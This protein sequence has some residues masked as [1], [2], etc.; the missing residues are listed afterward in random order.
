MTME[1]ES[2]SRL[3]IIYIFFEKFELVYIPKLYLPTQ[4]PL[5]TRQRREQN[6]WL[7]RYVI[8]SCRRRNQIHKNNSFWG[9]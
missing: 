7:T 6:N 2:N 4:Q 3:C 8:L 9:L 1:T 5:I